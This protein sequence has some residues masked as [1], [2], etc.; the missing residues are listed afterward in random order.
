[1]HICSQIYYGDA[2]CPLSSGLWLRKTGIW[3]ENAASTI[4]IPHL[5]APRNNDC[6]F[7]PR[8]LRPPV[9]CPTAP[10]I[11]LNKAI[12]TAWLLILTVVKPNIVSQ[13]NL[14]LSPQVYDYTQH[15]HHSSKR[16][17]QKGDFLEA[18]SNITLKS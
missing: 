3:P 7:W 18:V 14:N 11:S 17:F 1:M 9:F 4:L 10:A 8:N 12:M 15:T 5:R 6:T 2:L 16:L 13:V